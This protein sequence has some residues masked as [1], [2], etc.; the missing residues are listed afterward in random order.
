MKFTK[1]GNE[2]LSQ[3]P[4]AIP[5]DRTRPESLQ[6]QIARMVQSHFSM[7]ADNAG[8][9]T[10]EEANDFG[11]SEEFISPDAP[12]SSFQEEFLQQ[13]SLVGDNLNNDLSSQGVE[14]SA[15]GDGLKD[16]TPGSQSDSEVEKP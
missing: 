15:L 2:I 14:K 16:G 3:V 10:F 4:L 13:E 1:D 11:D 12:L 5:Y 9:E 8:E 7:M 6:E